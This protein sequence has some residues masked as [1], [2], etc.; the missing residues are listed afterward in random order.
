M[1]GEFLS[2]FGFGGCAVT[3]LG[4]VCLL[5]YRPRGWLYLLLPLISFIGLGLWHMGY[6]PAIHYFITR[7]LLL[8]RPVI[9][10]FAGLLARVANDPKL[11]RFAV[12]A[13]TLL[14]VSDAVHASFAWHG[15]DS[16]H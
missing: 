3:V 13:L 9:A 7:P 14:G 12:A 10:G 16:S 15:L 2:H 5:I 6:V 8:I 4:L 1:L 11:K